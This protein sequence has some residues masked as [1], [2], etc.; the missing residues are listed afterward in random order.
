MRSSRTRREFRSR[1]QPKL[2]RATSGDHHDIAR[3]FHAFWHETHAHLQPPEVAADRDLAF[4][5]KRVA[6]ARVAP[7][8]ARAQDGAILGFAIWNRHWLQSLFLAPVAR[9]TGLA[10]RLLAE[11]ERHIAARGHKRVALVCIVGND[12]AH[13]FYERHG[14]RVVRYRNAPMKTTRGDVIARGWVMQKSLR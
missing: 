3:V 6:N 1:P 4:F 10:S 5:E 14:Y 8:V 11:A 13:A 7:R 2:R 9:G 12:R